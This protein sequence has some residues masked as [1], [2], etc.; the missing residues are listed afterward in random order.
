[1]EEPGRGR[2]NREWERIKGGGRR[3]G[4]KGT[5]TEREGNR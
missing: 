5:H 1:M 3:M 4:Q 2:G